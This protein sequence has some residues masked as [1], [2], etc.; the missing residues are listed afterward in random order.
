VNVGQLK[1]RFS[2]PGSA[3]KRRYVVGV[4]ESMEELMDAAKRSAHVSYW[5]DQ[6]ADW[7]GLGP[8]GASSIARVCQLLSTGW[9][10]GADRMVK[11]LAGL[12]DVQ[13]KPKSVRRQNRWADQGDALDIHR[14]NAGRLDAAWQ[15]CRRE[16]QVG[17][18]RVTLVCDAIESGGNDAD[19]MFWRGAAVV[20]LADKLQSA[21]YNVEVVSA[22][23]GINDDVRVICHVTVKQSSQ[24]LDL[25]TLASAVACPAF[26]RALGHCWGNSVDGRRH[27]GGYSV[28]RWLAGPG[29]IVA[30]HDR[31]WDAAV[32]RAWVEA[33]IAALEANPVPVAA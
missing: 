25:T 31:T 18:Q 1:Q 28:G 2:T 6:S 20:T 24:P 14:V 11:A 13:V 9:T 21:G 17:P 32:A 4:F 3:I 5:S 15:K 23:T 33:Q 10:R 7:Y 19:T 22:W 27:P 8:E 26:F 30:T 16:P 29:E 12:A